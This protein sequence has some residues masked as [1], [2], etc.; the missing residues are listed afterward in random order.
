[1]EESCGCSSS[2]LEQGSW[3]WMRKRRRIFKGA[4]EM[5]WVLG[6]YERAKMEVSSG[7]EENRGGWDGGWKRW[8]VRGGGEGNME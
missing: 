2:S 1:M 6:N 3:R 5:K 7:S 4:T 8:M